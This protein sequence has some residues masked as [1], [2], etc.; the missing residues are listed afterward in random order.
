M[1]KLIIASLFTLLPTF[2]FADTVQ[3][4]I[5]TSLGDI[6][7]ELYESD[8]PISV[9]NFLRYVDEGWYENTIFHRV[10]P[11]FMIQGGG[12]TTNHQRKKTYSPIQNEA[13]NGLKN[14]RGTL[15]MARTNDPHSATSQFFINTVDNPALDHTHTGHPN[16]W[17]YAVFG[18]VT[19]GMEVV[20]KISRVPTRRAALSGYP[21]ND[22]PQQPVI[23]HSITR[24]ET[25]ENDT[26]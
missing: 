15:A 17:G 23:I 11:G 6:E 4:R 3:V 13:Q 1:K 20:D 9:E 25:N 19:D 21:A 22:V 7:A 24:I 14:T 5:S 8:A 18:K 2:T 26:P 10:I 12:F 16:S